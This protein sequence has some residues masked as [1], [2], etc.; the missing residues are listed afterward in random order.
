MYKCSPR[1]LQLTTVSR[2]CSAVHSMYL[3]AHLIIST[4]VKAASFNT[5]DV[6]LGIQILINHTELN[7][8]K[9][10]SSVIVHQ[11]HTSQLD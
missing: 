7:T 4:V 5:A 8:K 3:R 1:V 10:H 9:C 2:L 6:K 11:I